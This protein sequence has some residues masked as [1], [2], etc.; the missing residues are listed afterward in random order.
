[1]NYTTISISIAW[2]KKSLRQICYFWDTC[3][4][5]Y[6]DLYIDYENI[7][8]VYYVKKCDTQNN[9]LISKDT[10]ILIKFST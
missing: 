9:Y 10:T 7:R 3:F 2:Y 5:L 6:K 8:F 4:T 1:M